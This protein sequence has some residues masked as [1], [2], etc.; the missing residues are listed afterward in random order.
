MNI[1]AYN[2][3]TLR[4]LVRNLQAENKQLRNLLREKNIVC[5]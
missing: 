2:L 4:N 3:D 5:P 1:E